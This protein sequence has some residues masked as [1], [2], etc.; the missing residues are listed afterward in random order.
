MLVLVTL[1]WGVSYYFMD[2]SLNEVGPLTLNALRFLGAFAVAVILTFKQLKNPSKATIKYSIMIGTALVFVYAGA[3]FGVIYTTLSNAAFLC[4]LTVVFVPFVEF[5]MYGKKPQK[6]MILIVAMSFCGIALLTMKD[7]FS[8][9]TTTIFGDLLCVFCTVAYAVDLSIT[10]KALERE[11]VNAYQIG[12]FQ[13][14]VTGVLMSILALGFETPQL[15]RTAQVWFYVSFLAIFCTGLA[16]IVQ[17]IAQKYTTASRVGVIFTLEPV[18]A[19]IVAYLFAGEVLTTKSY[20]GG[21]ILVITILLCELNVFKK[22][23][24]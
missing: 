20:L 14:G 6:K 17:T 13:L 4:A 7:D 23:E 16:F 8:I 2:L 11:D 5:I 9:N 3:T 22:K 21:A 12:V 10:S 19:S 18:F 15:P 1:G 24:I